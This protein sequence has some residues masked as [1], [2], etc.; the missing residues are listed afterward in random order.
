MAETIRICSIDLVTVPVAEVDIEENVVYSE[1]PKIGGA[2]APILNFMIDVIWMKNVDHVN[3]TV[4]FEKE[5]GSRGED[6]HRTGCYRS[7]YRN[8]SDVALGMTDYPILD[9][10]EI[11]P[12]QVFFEEPF[13][14]LQGYNIST[15]PYNSDILSSSIKSTDLEIWVLLFNMIFAIIILFISNYTVMDVVLEKRTLKQTMI[16]DICFES[17]CLFISEETKDYK[18]SA[19]RFY[20]LLLTFG[21]FVYLLYFCN[22]MA[23]D[24]MVLDQPNV[25]LSFQEILDRPH[26][27]PT[28]IYELSE[29]RFF[30]AAGEG[31]V[32]NQLYQSVSERTN[33]GEP[34]FLHAT[35]LN[36]EAVQFP[37]R[38]SVGTTVVIMNRL[39]SN[40]VAYTVC[41]L[42]VG[43]G[44][45]PKTM[46]WTPA[47]QSQKM[48]QKGLIIRQ[49]LS[50]PLYTAKTYRRIRYS[51]ENGLAIKGK[52]V[53]DMIH[54]DDSAIVGDH[55]SVEGV[56]RCMSETLIFDIPA[57]SAPSITNFVGLYFFGFLM[58]LF[59]A[60]VFF[61]EFFMKAVMK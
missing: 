10:E 4:T 5:F 38:A 30:S 14:I 51:F 61:I 3:Y 40:F 35:E 44:V 28:F 60:M 43:S 7:I 48:Y 57:H 21:S 49:H 50:H 42:K 39:W 22:F 23:T 55:L 2:V 31:S 16:F 56:R 45:F 24:M 20:S 41:R 18:K 25:I 1:R 47:D 15:I 34:L 13:V 52:R 12:Y 19:T 6:G 9:F 32:E 59:S 33:E 54:I 26:V 36:M 58:T 11:N 17:F 37:I 53:L 46:I 29:Y 27:K 8:E